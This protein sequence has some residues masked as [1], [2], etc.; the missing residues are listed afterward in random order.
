MDERAPIPDLADAP[1]LV[2]PDDR[3]ERGSVHTGTGAYRRIAAALFLAG[4]ATFSLLYCVQP[5]LPEFA[6][7]FGVGAAESSLALSFTTGA[8]AIAIV[9]AAALS[10]RIG[11]RGLMAG[12]MMGAAAIT[13]L[14]GLTQ[15]WPAFLALRAAEGVV[16]GGVPAV[17]MAYLAEEID[18]AGLGRAMGVYVAG[19]AFGGMIGRVGTGI[20]VEALSWRAAIVVVGLFGLASAAAFFLLLPPS[21]HFRP[22]HGL[23]IGHHLAA[24]RGHLA[25]GRLLALFA[26]AFLAMGAF[27]AVYNYA[28]FRLTAPPYGLDQTGLGL[29]FLVYTA[30]VVGS[31][32]VGGLADR[33]GR[34]RALALCIAIAI[35]GIA[36]T[37]LTPLPLVI[38]GMAMMTF[39]FFGAHAVAS[40]WV[41]RLARGSKGHASSLYLLGY[42]LGSSVLG[43]AGGWFWQAAGWPGVVAFT[44]GL[45]ALAL[46]AARRVDRAAG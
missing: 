12:S 45:F 32:L 2:E 20:L 4:F 31:S 16:L 13:I 8:L 10:E 37:L 17:A 44:I 26:I 7:D 42:Y 1:V 27:V 25:D 18:P 39:G 22:R 23:G 43:S 24:W 36:T 46:L 35:I 3:V 15:G 33:R 41:G 40:G 14:A 11:R 38:A 9:A 19:T 6:R 28:G 34:Y 30:G 29:V 5:L 21:R